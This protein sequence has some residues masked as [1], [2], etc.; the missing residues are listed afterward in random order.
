MHGFQV[1]LD[2]P[3]NLGCKVAVIQQKATM[4]DLCR[5]VVSADVTGAITVRRVAVLRDHECLRSG[6]IEHRGLIL[7]VNGADGDAV[8]ASR[9]QVVDQALFRR[10]PGGGRFVGRAVTHI[11]T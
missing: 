8:D 5:D 7:R 1:Q 3:H 9:Q 4:C 6:A 10:E 11:R 2:D